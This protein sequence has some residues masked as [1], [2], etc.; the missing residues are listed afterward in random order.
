MNKFVVSYEEQ[1][2]IKFTLAMEKGIDVSFAILTDTP[3]AEWTYLAGKHQWNSFILKNERFQVKK[4]GFHETLT[5]NDLIL[6]NDG[7]HELFRQ[8]KQVSSFRLKMLQLL[9]DENRKIWNKV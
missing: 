3:S 7:F 2:G 4:V 8:I 6:I 9:N 1:N 5:L